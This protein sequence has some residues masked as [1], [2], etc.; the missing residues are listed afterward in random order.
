MTASGELL[1]VTE[2]DQPDIF[3]A[4]PMSYGTLGFLVGVQLRLEKYRPY[5]R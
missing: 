1:T 5:I 3:R 2:R 4:L